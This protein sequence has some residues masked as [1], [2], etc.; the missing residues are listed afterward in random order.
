M[1]P[2]NMCRREYALAV[3]QIMKQLPSGNEVSIDLDGWI[4]PNKLA[5]PS[6]IASYIHRTWALREV[7]LAF[8]EVDCLFFSCFESSL[9][10]IG[11]GPTYCSKASHTFK[12]RA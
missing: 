10:M 9:W 1:T 11:E 12:G 6:V 4:S 3:D 5:I 8:D 2:S 7:Q